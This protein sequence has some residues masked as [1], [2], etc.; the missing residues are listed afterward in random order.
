MIWFN[1]LF[2]F[3]QPKFKC[4]WSNP[5]HEQVLCISPSFHQ[6]LIFLSWHDDLLFLIGFLHQ[7][8]K[9]QILLSFQRKVLIFGRVGTKILNEEFGKQQFDSARAQVFVDFHLSSG[10]HLCI[11]LGKTFDC[12]EILEREVTN[13]VIQEIQRGF[14]NKRLTFWN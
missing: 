5:F 4:L 14:L 3:P 6:L 1:V 8:L 12:A 10:I 2:L 11:I 13:H 9:K 7:E